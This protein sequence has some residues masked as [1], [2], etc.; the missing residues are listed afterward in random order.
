MTSDVDYYGMPDDS[1][2]LCVQVIINR[3][4]F[5]GHALGSNSLNYFFFFPFFFFFFVLTFI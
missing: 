5:R 1:Y 3:S 2:E 4:N